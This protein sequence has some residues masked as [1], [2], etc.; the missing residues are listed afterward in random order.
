ML[1]F[2]LGDAPFR[3]APTGVQR[4]VDRLGIITVFEPNNRMMSHINTQHDERGR[5]R[6]GGRIGQRV[7]EENMNSSKVAGVE[8]IERKR[9]ELHASPHIEHTPILSYP[10]ISIYGYV[11]TI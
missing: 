6:G 3:S 7:H 1:R 11:L 9:Q 2:I 4:D 8:K 10:Y 5:G